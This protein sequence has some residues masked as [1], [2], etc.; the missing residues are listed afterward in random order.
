MN[1]GG[2]IESFIPLLQTNLGSN[3]LRKELKEKRQKELTLILREHTNTEMQNKSLHIICIHCLPRISY[4][5]LINLAY[6]SRKRKLNLSSLIRT[7]L[8]YY[9]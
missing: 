7:H 2:L 3:F 4:S 6:T 1:V 8:K 9:G 5:L